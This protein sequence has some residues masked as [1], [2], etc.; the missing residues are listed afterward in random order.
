MLLKSVSRSE[1]EQL[2]TTGKGNLRAALR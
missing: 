1:A 2:L